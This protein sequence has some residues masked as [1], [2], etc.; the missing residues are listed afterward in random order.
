MTAFAIHLRQPSPTSRRFSFQREGFGFP[1]KVTSGMVDRR[2]ATYAT[3]H[4][5][6][7][8]GFLRC[9]IA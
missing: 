4:T 1:R 2:N 7:K 6:S 3:E 8:L 5:G 9:N